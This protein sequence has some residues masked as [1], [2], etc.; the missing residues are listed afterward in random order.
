MLSV[1]L[2]NWNTSVESRWKKKGNTKSLEKGKSGEGK[3][4]G[5]KK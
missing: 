1:Q 2:V 4:V 5:V 3:G